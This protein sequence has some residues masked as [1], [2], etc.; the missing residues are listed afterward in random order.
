MLRQR[1]GDKTF[2]RGLQQFYRENKFKRATFT[3]LKNAFSNAAAEDLEAEFN[4]WTSRAGAP[5]L[6]VGQAQ[7]EPHNKGYRLTAILE[8]VQPGPV[9]Q[10]RLPLAVSLEGQEQAYQRTVMMAGKRL[11]LVLDVPARPLHL[12][13]D[14]EF[15]LFRRLDR[16]EIPP[17]LSLAFSGRQVLILLPS[18]ASKKVLGG[19]RALAESWTQYPATQLQIRMDSELEELPQD[20]TIWL[21]GWENRFQPKMIQQVAVYRVSMTDGGLQIGETR[22][23]RDK[24]AA[25]L[26]TRHPANPELALAWLATDNV[27]AIPGLGQKLAHYGK[28]SYLGFEGS[29]PV[30]TLKGEWPVVGS[31]LSIPV[32][33][34]DGSVIQSSK[35][36]L[37]P[38]KALIELP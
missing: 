36:K 16:T 23:V 38:R 37:A 13:V 5:V 32:T 20:R 11:N 30:N 14:P 2:I 9:Y 4:Q 29:E 6:R 22:L 3:D 26:V 28:Y 15:D 10:L 31:A 25:V 17:A 7:A 12:E 1:L 35:P 19:Y 34:A 27:L 18:R 33:Q 8:Q 24:H 21:F